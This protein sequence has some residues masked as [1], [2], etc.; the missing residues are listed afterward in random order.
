MR[1]ASYRVRGIARAPTHL[2]NEQEMRQLPTATQ[3]PASN[4]IVKFKHTLDNGK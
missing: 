3:D 4:A 1:D 2:A